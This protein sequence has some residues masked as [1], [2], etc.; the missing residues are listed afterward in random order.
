MNFSL[1]RFFPAAVLIA[2]GIVVMIIGTIGVFRIHYVL[3]RLHAAAM[4]DSLGLLLIALGLTILCGWSLSSL[5]LLMM[6][7]LFWIAS[8]VCSHLLSGLEAFTNDELE[9]ECQ[10]ITLAELEGTGGEQE[11]GQEA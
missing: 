1:L 11:G 10:I 8:P 5:K 6:V 9:E 2:A 7:T 3:N 4:G